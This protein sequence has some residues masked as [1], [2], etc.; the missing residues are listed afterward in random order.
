MILPVS[1]LRKPCQNGRK[2][3]RV[4]LLEFI[5]KLPQRR[6]ARSVFIEFY[7]KFHDLSTSNLVYYKVAE[8]GQAIVMRYF[9]LAPEIKSVFSF[10]IISSKS[11]RL[12]RF[13][14][15]LILARL[16]TILPLTTWNLGGR[17]L[18]LPGLVISQE[19]AASQKYIQKGI[20]L[21]K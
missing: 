1:Q 16:I 15:T 12:P 5:Q 8:Q 18:T 13:S 20:P 2:I 11:W 14:S 19:V 6:S 3:V 10:S 17:A 9:F 21:S 7:S 4:G